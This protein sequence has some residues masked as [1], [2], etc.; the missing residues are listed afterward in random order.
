MAFL[1]TLGRFAGL[2]LEKGPSLS[3]LLALRRQRVKL[4][5]LSDHELQDIGLT[6][7]DVSQELSRSLFDVPCNWRG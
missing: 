2:S 3:D 7:N 4:A 5:S 6:P 1:N